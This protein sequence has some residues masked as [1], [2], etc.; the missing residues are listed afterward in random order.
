MNRYFCFV[1]RMKKM[2]A[3]HESFD[4]MIKLLLR[5]AEKKEFN[6][7]IICTAVKSEITMISEHNYLKW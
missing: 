1:E 6:W 3:L 5:H 4:W 7:Q 2:R